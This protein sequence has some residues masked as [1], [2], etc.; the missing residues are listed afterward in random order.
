MATF[1]LVHGTSACAAA[2]GPVSEQLRAAGHEVFAPTLTGLGEREHLLTRSVGLET[3]ISDVLDLL[4]HNGL[5][6]VVLVGHSYG[7]MVISGVVGRVPGRIKE[8]IYLDALVPEVDE[9]VI[10]LVGEHVLHDVKTKVWRLGNGW[11]IPVSHGPHDPSRLNTPHPWK[12]WTDRLP[13]FPIRSPLTH[14]IPRTYIRCT[15]DK[16]AGS[17]FQLGFE[18]SWQRVLAQRSDWRIVEVD[19]VHQIAV[20]PESKVAALLRLYPAARPAAHSEGRPENRLRTVEAPQGAP[21]LPADSVNSRVAVEPIKT[22]M[23][24]P[25]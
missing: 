19:T 17:V 25:A 2:W 23:P 8:L 4:V 20:D 22:A 13:S 9:A 11:L 10:D 24:A 12:S 21:I 6:D 7:G 14:F 15:A 18:R 3:H 16:H 5:H 1:V